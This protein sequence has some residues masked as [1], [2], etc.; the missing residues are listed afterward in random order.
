LTRYNLKGLMQDHDDLANLLRKT[1]KRAPEYP[2]ILQWLARTKE[3]LK[4][5]TPKS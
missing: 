4:C 2:I 1:R 3:A 5:T